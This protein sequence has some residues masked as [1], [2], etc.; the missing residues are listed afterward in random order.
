VRGKRMCGAQQRCL[1]ASAGSIS[2]DRW[3]DVQSN[4]K[5]VFPMS[6]VLGVTKT[7][8]PATDVMA[9]QGQATPGQVLTT[10]SLVLGSLSDSSNHDEHGVQDRH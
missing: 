5:L 1:P 4:M 6:V 9:V 3:E 2:F 8:V 10:C 7:L